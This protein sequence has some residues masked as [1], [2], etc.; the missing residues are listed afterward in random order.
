MPKITEYASKIV[1]KLY[2]TDA[3]LLRIM[4]ATLYLRA[5]HS[6][7]VTRR[8]F[9][10]RVHCKRIKLD[11]FEA[12]NSRPITLHG[13]LVLFS[14]GQCF[15]NLPGVF[16]QYFL[17]YSLENINNMPAVIDHFVRNISQSKMTC[18]LCATEI[19]FRSL[20]EHLTSLKRHLSIKHPE[21]VAV[22]G[23]S[24]SKIPK[25]SNFCVP[26]ASASKFPTLSKLDRVTIAICVSSHGLPFNIVEDKNFGW[27]FKARSGNF[28]VHKTSANLLLK[29]PVTEAA[30]ERAFSRHKI[31]HT[32]LRANLKTK[33]L[34]TQLFIW[35]NFKRILKIAS[36]DSKTEAVGEILTWLC[37]VDIA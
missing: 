34:E 18:K 16:Y 17:R 3:A 21:T 15:F 32:R 29:M 20:N 35:Y 11:G 37:N 19:V 12:A 36:K 9:S 1:Q 4:Q 26:K 23:P 6:V 22:D 14:V 2:S 25:I 27:V 31:V 10:S 13:T 5:V 28:P 8:L 30:V 24:G 7:H 33:N